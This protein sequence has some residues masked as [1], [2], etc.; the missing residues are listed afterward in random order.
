M[1]K[2]EKMVKLGLEKQIKGLSFLSRVMM[3]EDVNDDSLD[4]LLEAINM[5]EKAYK[6]IEVEQ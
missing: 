4:Y 1:D 6:E 3:I 2:P 5:L